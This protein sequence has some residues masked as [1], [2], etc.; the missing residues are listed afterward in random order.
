MVLMLI[1]TLAISVS[2]NAVDTLVEA[3][4]KSNSTGT[5]VGM[6]TVV[7]VALGVLAAIFLGAFLVLILVICRKQRCYYVRHFL[8]IYLYQL[9]LLLAIASLLFESMF[10]FLVACDIYIV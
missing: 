10:F 9:Y 4:V 8:F 6:E 1:S 2:S 5:F 7:A 3:A